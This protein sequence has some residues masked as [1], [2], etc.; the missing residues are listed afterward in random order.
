MIL[1]QFYTAILER[2]TAKE[3][4][5]EYFDL[6]FDQISRNAD[7]ED[8]LFFNYPAIFIEMQPIQWESLGRKKEARRASV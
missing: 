5:M 3:V 6:W 4:P 8:T 2:L 1:S 7:D